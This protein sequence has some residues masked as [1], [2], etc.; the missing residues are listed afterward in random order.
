[1]A[2]RHWLDILISPLTL[3]TR[4]RG[5]RQLGLLALYG[6][7]LGIAGVLIGR[8]A[9]LWR[10]PDAPEPFDL[11]K[12]GHVELADAD[13]A[14]VLYREAIR[15]LIRDEPL[16]HALPR[17][18]A[19]GWNWAAADPRVREWAGRNRP[20]LDLWL[21]GADRPDCLLVQ[22]EEHRLDTA[23]DP[24][25]DLQI[26]MRLGALEATRRQAAGDLAGAW[27]CYRGVLRTCMHAGRR[28]ATNAAAVGAR[29]LAGTSPLVITWAS[30]PNTTPDLLR[31]AAADLADCRLRA[32]TPADLIRT[33]YFVARASLADPDRWA[34]WQRNEGGPDSWY[35]HFPGVLWGQNFLR[36]EPK[37]SL[38]V[39]RLLTTGYLAQADRP[40]A[41]RSRVA[42]PRY[43]IFAVDPSTPDPLTR[44]KP[45]DLAAWADASGCRGSELDPGFGLGFARGIETSLDHLRLNLAERAYALDHAEQ[46]P[47]TYGDLLPTYFDALPPGFAPGDPL[48]AP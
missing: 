39:L 14:M 4:T 16:W 44:I 3:L 5:R 28:G 6:L 32:G 8:E 40:A 36:N 26:L 11:A 2:Q 20:A 31:R 13:N 47:T 45:E 17:G 25:A 15:A 34:N 48:T 27:V 7:I 24:I 29:G 19:D 18:S 12:Y 9:V 35:R 1:M 46:P 41:D 33:E 21:R 10:L 37:R 43:L 38:K 23:L 30:D 42:V 22:P